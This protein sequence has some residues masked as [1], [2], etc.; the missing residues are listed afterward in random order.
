MLMLTLMLMMMLML[1]KVSKLRTSSDS[2]KLRY[3][4][5]LSKVSKLSKPSKQSKPRKPIKL[6][7]LW[8]EVSQSDIILFGSTSYNALQHHTFTQCITLQVITYRAKGR[9]NDADRACGLDKKNKLT[10]T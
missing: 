2:S 5:M 9:C 7:K 10:I 6:S 3:V 1:N 8:L 4:S